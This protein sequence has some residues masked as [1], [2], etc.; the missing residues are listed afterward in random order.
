MTGCAVPSTTIG[1]SRLRRH[2]RAALTPIAVCGS[3]T[4]P[5]AANT[6]AMVSQVCSSLTASESNSLRAS[7]QRSCSTLKPPPCLKLAISS[8][9][10]PPLR[11]CRSNSRRSKL[12][13][14]MMSIDGDRVACRVSLTYWLPLMKRCRMSLRLVA[15]ISW[16]TGRPMLRA[17]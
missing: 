14:T 2:S 17:R 6:S 1:V 4:S 7:V 13:E 5:V 10:A 11:P 12:D 8:A 3:S 15:T 16:L 9:I